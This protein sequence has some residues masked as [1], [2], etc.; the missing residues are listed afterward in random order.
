MAAP[1]AGGGAAW[2]G[3]GLRHGRHHVRRGAFHSALWRRTIM[4]TM[5]PRTSPTTTVTSSSKYGRPWAGSIG[6]STSAIEPH[7]PAVAASRPEPRRDT[8]GGAVATVGFRWTSGLFCYRRA[9]KGG[10]PA[11][12]SSPPPAFNPIDWRGMTRAGSR[13]RQQRRPSPQGAQEEDAA[14]GHLPRDEAPRPLRE[15]IREERAE[16]A[17]AVR[18]ARKLARKRMQREGLLPMKPKP[19]TG[20]GGPARAPRRPS[21]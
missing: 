16:K 15:A 5:R 6:A 7:D 9:R 21:F 13:P 4:T 19:T 2:S 14:R 18:R 12:A 10:V 11:P 20:P 8:P 1:R 3:R 17:E